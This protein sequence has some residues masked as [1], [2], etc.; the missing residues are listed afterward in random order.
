VPAILRQ[1]MAGVAPKSMTHSLVVISLKTIPLQHKEGCLACLRVLAMLDEDMQVPPKPFRIVLSAILGGN[2]VP[3]LKMRHWIQLLISRSLIIN[4]WEQPALHDIVR[5]TL[6]AQMQTERVEKLMRMTTEDRADI[7]QIKTAFFNSKSSD[8]MV[9]WQRKRLENMIWSVVDMPLYRKIADELATNPDHQSELVELAIVK[10]ILASNCPEAFN[11]YQVRA[12]YLLLT[13]GNNMDPVECFAMWWKIPIAKIFAPKMHVSSAS[14]ALLDVSVHMKNNA[15][16][17]AVAARSLLSR[18]LATG[19]IASGLW[20][21]ASG[22]SNSD[23]WEK[24]FGTGGRDLIAVSRH[25]VLTGFDENHMKLRKE[26]GWDLACGGGLGAALAVHWGDFVAAD[27][28]WTN[29]VTLYRRIS[30]NDPVQEAFSVVNAF[31]A[32]VIPMYF[33]GRGQQCAQWLEE[34]N[35]TWSSSHKTLA[36]VMPNALLD[37]LYSRVMWVWY[38]K[39]AHA[40][41]AEEL[42]LS[43]EDLAS[44]PSPT[45]L[46]RLS[47][48]TLPQ[49]VVDHTTH[50][51]EAFVTLSRKQSAVYN[52]RPMPQIVLTDD[53]GLMLQ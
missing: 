50:H 29:M 47:A 5:E 36:S 23:E 28:L 6:L 37:V 3:E 22:L 10:R 44:V 7:E 20:P 33:T 45:E 19:P 16:G 49:G 11:R 35:W 24:L 17:H 8:E 31:P 18:A 21:M 53:D 40:L 42:H 4:T 48:A 1:H 51:V 15:D 32:A 2:K 27:E 9:A 14:R 13:H 30:A 38:C 34:F 39:C 46:L 12:T 25:H 41:C 43:A 26:V 52:F